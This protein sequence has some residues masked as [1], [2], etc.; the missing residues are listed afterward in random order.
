M[1]EGVTLITG[2]SG[3]IGHHL[4]QQCLE[5]DHA[6]RVLDL[7][8]FPDPVAPID[9]RRGSI[10]DPDFVRDA[11]K[12]VRR[13]YHCAANPNLWA[14]NKASFFDTNTRG[15]QIILEK[16]I[17]AGVERVIHTSTESIMKN[18]RNGGSGKTINEQA[19]I[20]V[21]DVPGPYCKSKWLAEK[22]ALDALEKGLDLV[23][24]NP[25][26]PVGPGDRLLTPPSRMLLDFLS[27]KNPAYLECQLSFI[28]VRDVAAG[29]RLAME[30]GRRGEKYILSGHILKMS[31]LLKLLEEISG[32]AMPRM[33]VPYTLALISGMISEWV[34]DHFTHQYPKASLTGVRLVRSAM[35]YDN[36]KALQELGLRIRPFRE[37]LADAV[38]WFQSN[39]L[40]P[41]SE[42]ICFDEDSR[43]L[44][45]S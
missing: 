10:T 32:V 8:P 29:H 13:V 35:A 20:K 9:F 24:V 36:R 21:E 45:H 1:A 33:Q 40:L 6:V 23:V 17:E 39:D 19:Q 28:D 31:E 37:S 30:K 4:V 11:M 27:G 38:A 2:G 42:A 43:M 22:A 25:T 18:F 16:A 7:Q 26:L 14:R 3:F 12:D 15:T 44:S 5:K 34:A 41:Q